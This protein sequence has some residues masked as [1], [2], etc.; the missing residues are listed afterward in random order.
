MI[1]VFIGA[2]SFFLFVGCKAIKKV[3]HLSKGSF[4]STSM[5]LKEIKKNELI[6]KSYQSTGRIEV[7]AKGVSA[8]ARLRVRMIKDSALWVNISF[9]GITAYRAY[10]TKDS[11]FVLDKRK[12][13]Y[14][15]E[16]FRRIEKILGVKLTLGQVQSIFLGSPILFSSK[17]KHYHL[18]SDGLRTQ[19]NYYKPTFK[20]SLVD[21][22]SVWFKPKSS[23][24]EKQLFY[25]KD[26]NKTLAI[27]YKD[28]KVTLPQ[29]E[30][31]MA[32]LITLVGENIDNQ[33]SIDFRQIKWNDP[34]SMP[35]QIPT[36]YN[37]LVLE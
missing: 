19:F 15:K 32:L 34:V 18:I 23:M 7:D 27:E 16:P 29:I 25:I 26:K 36:Q 17:P 31:P 8:S 35:F 33:L 37:R 3:D 2:L 30:T 28:F 24:V 21:Q 1:R 22:W 5:V 20:R 11:I 14:I 12:R 10:A 9:L 4:S 6:Y 13:E